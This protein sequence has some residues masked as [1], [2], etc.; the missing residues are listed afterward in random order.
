[1]DFYWRKCNEIKKNYL[2][3]LEPIELNQLAKEAVFYTE[4]SVI[5]ESELNYLYGLANNFSESS[6]A[7]LLDILNTVI[8][9]LAEYTKR[10]L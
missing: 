4:N 7:K 2:E 5:K 9:V 10:N 6:P 8:A 3:S 1:M